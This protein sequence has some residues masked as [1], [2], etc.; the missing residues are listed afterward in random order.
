MPR[1]WLYR[2]DDT[3]VWS[4]STGDVPRHQANQDRGRA[5]GRVGQARDPVDSHTWWKP[6]GQTRMART[7]PALARA[8]HA[9][10]SA[11]GPI[12]ESSSQMGATGCWVGGQAATK[13]LPPVDTWPPRRPCQP[14]ER[15][16]AP[17]R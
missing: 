11:A 12:W 5:D 8:A 6:H 7:R 13:T 4:R 10:I 15:A 3:R 17:R 1:A 16:K 14:P 2:H 9:A